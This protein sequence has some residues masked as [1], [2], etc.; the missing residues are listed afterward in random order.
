MRIWDDIAQKYSQQK[1]QCTISNSFASKSNALPT[2]LYHYYLNEI[3]AQCVRGSY[4]GVCILLI[5]ELDLIK[6]IML[7]SK[8]CFKRLRLGTSERRIAGKVSDHVTKTKLQLYKQFFCFIII[9]IYEENS[10]F[11][12]FRKLTVSFISFYIRIAE[13]LGEFGNKNN[14]FQKNDF[15]LALQVHYQKF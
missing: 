1:I 12:R 14:N 5:F 7:S 9:I 3:K 15:I 10:F 6:F 13:N 11:Q 8:K 4:C 2:K